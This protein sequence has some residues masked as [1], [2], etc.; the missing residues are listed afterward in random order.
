MIKPDL[1]EAFG[2]EGQ[3]KLWDALMAHCHECIQ[4]EVETAISRET[5]ASI[6]ST[7]PAGRRP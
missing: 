5:L 6:A 4:D 3:N 7:P 1:L 2:F